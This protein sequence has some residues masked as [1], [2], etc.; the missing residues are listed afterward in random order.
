MSSDSR[1]LVGAHPRQAENFD[2]NREALETLATR[3]L[4]IGG[5]MLVVPHDDPQ[6]VAMEIALVLRAGREFDPSGAVLDLGETSECHANSV[7]LWRN[8]RGAFCT[9]YAL[10]DDAKW[11]SHSWIYD[12]AGGAVIETTE[13]RAGYFGHEFDDDGA[14]IFADL[15]SPE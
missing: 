11:R 4:Q 1:L 12:R 14:R 6:F 9:G 5:D 10:S 2:R 8:G 7:R 3:L 15:I 13:E